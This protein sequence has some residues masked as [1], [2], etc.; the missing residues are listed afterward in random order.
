MDN[1]LLALLVANALSICLLAWLAARLFELHAN[2]LA[3]YAVAVE[4]AAIWQAGAREASTKAIAYLDAV[5]IM[6]GRS[7]H[8]G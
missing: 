8:A 7:P 2:S 1:K 4:D 3:R 5:N 6:A